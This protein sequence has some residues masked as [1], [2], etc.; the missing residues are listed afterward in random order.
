METHTYENQQYNELIHHF[1]SS[2]YPLALFKGTATDAKPII[3]IT[4]AV[5]K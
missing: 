5:L 3:K 1:S 2:T 4:Y